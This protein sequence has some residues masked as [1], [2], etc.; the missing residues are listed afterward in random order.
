VTGDSQVYGRCQEPLHNGVKGPHCKGATM[1]TVNPYHT[2]S[3]EYPADQRSVHHNKDTCP[4]GKRIQRVHR[5]PGTG[6][7]PLCKECPKVT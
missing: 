2:N 5:V 3:Q 1:A 4:D 6:Q 7:R